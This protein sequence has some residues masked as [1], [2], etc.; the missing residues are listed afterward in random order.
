[1][2]KLMLT[3]LLKKKNSVSKQEDRMCCRPPKQEK[4][5]GAA[6]P[7]HTPLPQP[8]QG[9][10]WLHQH[11]PWIQQ[12]GGQDLFRA[13]AIWGLREWLLGSV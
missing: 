7:L 3:I 11:L 6:T 12:L 1:M 2:T 13:K 9:K 5:W 10:C 4:V 8:T